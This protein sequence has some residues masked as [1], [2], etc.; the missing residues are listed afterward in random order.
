MGFTIVRFNGTY[1]TK[2]DPRLFFSFDSWRVN[3]GP[4]LWLPAFIYSE[5]STSRNSRSKLPTF[6]AQTRLWG[7][8]RG[9]R[10]QGTGTGHGHR[11]VYLSDQGPIAAEIATFTP[12]Q[13]Q[14]S[15]DRQGEDNVLDGLQRI[16]LIAPEGD[17]DKVLD[18]V[19]NNLEVTN[20]LDF[21]PEVRCRVLMTSTIESF[22]L[23]HTIVLSRGMIDVLPDEA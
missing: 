9:P 22:D 8:Q 15:W 13:A 18:T 17:V 16:G 21:E 12:L 11:R 20:N 5:Q 4:N 6:K 14:R 10:Q 1:S 23:G 19:V 2:N 3:A 7:Y